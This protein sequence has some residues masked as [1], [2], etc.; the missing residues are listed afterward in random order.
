MNIPMNSPCPSPRLRGAALAAAAVLSSVA[1][2]IS[3]DILWSGPLTGTN[4]WNN[5]ANWAGGSF[6]NS[7]DDR[8]DLRQD[9]TTPSIINLSAPVTIN[10]VIFD[11]TGTNAGTAVV[12]SNGGTAANTLMLAGADPSIATLDG[13]TLSI[14]ANL[15]SDAGFVK[16]GDGFLLISGSNSIFGDLVVSEGTLAL[17]GTNAVNSDTLLRVDPGAVLRVNREVKVAGLND[18]AGAGGAVTNTSGGAKTLNISG[19]GTFSFAGRISGSTSTTRVGLRVSGATATQILAGDNTANTGYQSVTTSGGTLVFAKQDSI[20]QGL[21]AGAVVNANNPVNPGI[22]VTGGGTVALG[23]GDASEGYF[24]AAAIAL[25]LDP[26][27]MGASS[28]EDGGFR[29][30]SF[31]GFDTANAAGGIFTYSGALTDIGM[32]TFNG[33][34]KLGAGTLVL[35]AESYYTGNT[36]VRQ[37]TLQIGAGGTSGSI[38]GG[39][40]TVSSGATLAFNRSDDMARGNR[41][42]GAGAVAQIGAGTTTMSSTLS[43]YS[44]GTTISAGRLIAATL[45]SGTVTISGTANQLTLNQSTIFSNAVEITGAAGLVSQGLISA[46]AGINA[47]LAGPVSISAVPTEGGHFASSDTGTITVSGPITSSVDVWFRRGTGIFSGGGSY[48]NLRVRGGTLK[49]GAGDG[50]ATSTAVALGGDGPAVLD[51]NGFDQS[52]TG[53]TKGFNAATVLNNGVSDATL[54]TTGTSLYAGVI[55]DG[56]AK[57]SLE[58]NGG[59]L[60]LAGIN[61]HTGDTTITD[62]SLVLSATGAL[63]FAIGD[64]GTNNA[65]RGTG[66]AQIDGQFFFDLAGAATNVGA[67][68]TIVGGSVAGTYGATFLVNGF[69]GSGGRW[70]NTT[71]GVSYVFSQSNSVLTVQ[72]ASADNYAAWAGYWQG[73]YPGFTGPDAAGSAD[74]DGDGFDNDKEFAFDGNPMVGTPALLT[75]VKSGTNAVFNYVARKNPPGGVSYQVQATT[76]LATGP[77]TDAAVTVSN[78][79]NTNGLNIP[80]DYERK[81]FQQPIAGKEFYRVEATLAP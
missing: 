14:G 24:D 12:I 64:N 66:T 38:T 69:N 41:I 49:V 4:T 8:A 55:Q 9:W 48:T 71:N 19:F 23:V 53:L 54:T 36:Q 34:A 43:D 73:V 40:I 58:V 35:D 51:L 18:N 77:W 25:F 68:W 81:E 57:V 52:L 3:A 17:N 74:P 60:T 1:P 28:N 72:A 63:T 46:G 80:A 15:Q 31:L 76:N 42:T 26:D 67:S 59:S 5:G 70:T 39:I 79:A 2:G 50:L 29:N 13:S 47:E 11:D 61:T 10:G 75:A 32:S 37:G 6:P 21:S 30:G 45:G 65:V 44:G 20:F 22:N 78:S 56:T 7:P 33:F 62:G 27:H 16:T